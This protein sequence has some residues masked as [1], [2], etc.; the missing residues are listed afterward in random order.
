VTIVAI[1]EVQV[2]AVDGTR[3]AKVEVASVEVAAMEDPLIAMEH[4]PDAT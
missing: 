4:T 2:E 3:A 1:L